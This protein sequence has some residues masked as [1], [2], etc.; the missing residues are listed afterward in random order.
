M[1][2]LN[3]EII[4]LM[5]ENGANLVG[6]S[7]LS[8][9][10]DDE[11]NIGVCVAVAINKDI[12]EGIKDGPNIEYFGEYNKVNDILD[13]LVTIGAEFLKS[14]GYKAY[15]N[16]R[17][18][19]KYGRDLLTK[20][21]HKTVATRAGL[22][23]IGKCAVLVTKEYG[24]AVRISTFLTNAPLELDNPINSSYCGSCTKC[25]DNCPAEAILGNEWNVNSNR[26]ELVDAFACEKKADELCIKNFGI[27]AS[28]CGKCIEV[29]P[30]TKKYI[31]SVKK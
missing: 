8:S 17:S 23:W 25:K 12:I 16:T 20:L 31:N 5:K 1:L 29:C 21:P 6:F 28:I 15:A 13:N 11:L 26:E 30:F 10:K 9:I 14:K 19:T 2:S 4:N 7:D 18:V 22:G 27:A 24:S 3:E